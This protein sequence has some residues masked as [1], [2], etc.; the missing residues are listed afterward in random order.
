[1]DNSRKDSHLNAL[2]REDDKEKVNGTN[3]KGCQ[4][5]FEEEDL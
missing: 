1:M 5:R 4:L 3:K 2:P